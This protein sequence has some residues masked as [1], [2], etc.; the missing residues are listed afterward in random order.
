MKYNPWLS[1]IQNGVQLS[2]HSEWSTAELLGFVCV[3]IFLAASATADFLLRH[4]MLIGLK[5]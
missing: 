5:A 4:L 1:G 2:W 3:H